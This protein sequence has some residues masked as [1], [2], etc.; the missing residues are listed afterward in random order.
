MGRRRYLV[1]AGLRSLDDMAVLTAFSLCKAYVAGEVGIAGWMV[2]FS[3]GRRMGIIRWG[4]SRAGVISIG[5]IPVRKM[6]RRRLAGGAK[7][8]GTGR[9]AV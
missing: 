6:R 4:K 7:G 2:R 5:I 1:G 9:G 3:H 8:S